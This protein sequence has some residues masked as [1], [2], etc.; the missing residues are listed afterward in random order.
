M[1]NY[2]KKLKRKKRN[3]YIDELTWDRYELPKNIEGMELLNKVNHNISPS[4]AFDIAYNE[5]N[6]IKDYKKNFNERVRGDNFNELYGVDKQIEVV[7]LNN[8][9]YWQIKILD[10][11]FRYGYKKDGVIHDCKQKIKSELCRC[12]IN[13]VTGEY[14]YYP[15]IK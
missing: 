3:K 1:F 9:I 7:R 12:L 11:Y 15:E 8:K 2:L 14:I 4:D 5:E 13:V 6:L 10:G